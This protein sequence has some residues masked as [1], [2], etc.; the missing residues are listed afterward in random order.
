MTDGCL[1]HALLAFS[2]AGFQI[3]ATTFFQSI[4]CVGK[5]IFLSLARQVIFL[6]PLLLW[7]PDF[8]GLNGVWL[9]FPGSDICATVVTAAMIVYEFRRIN[10]RIPVA[11][12]N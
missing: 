6:I 1:S 3:V 2:V 12:L 5:S 8:F 7:L 10:R 4:G 9:S 11:G